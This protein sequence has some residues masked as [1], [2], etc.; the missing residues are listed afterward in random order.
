MLTLEKQQTN[1]DKYKADLSEKITGI[2]ESAQSLVGE[3][4]KALDTKYQGTLDQI[5]SLI[6]NYTNLIGDS[7]GIEN[8]LNNLF[9]LADYADL[10]QELEKS[11]ENR[12][13]QGIKDLLKD[14]KYSDLLSAINEKKI[15][16]DD[17]SDYIMAIAAPEKKILKV[18][19]KT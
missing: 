16:E 12:G 3:D 5:D 11:W 15:T 7:S 14:T 10:K 2:S 18:S 6:S 4:G 8:K 13:S 19:S 9:A 1:I 17:L